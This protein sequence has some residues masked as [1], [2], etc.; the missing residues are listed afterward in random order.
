[1]RIQAVICTF[2]P[3]PSQPNLYRLMQLRHQFIPNA[4]RYDH[5]FSK[6][7]KYNRVELVSD[8]PEGNDA[9]VI[10]SLQVRLDLNSLRLLYAKSPLQICVP[11]VT[12]SWEHSGRLKFIDRGTNHHYECDR[13]ELRHYCHSSI[14]PRTSSQCTVR[15]E[16]IDS[17]KTNPNR[18]GTL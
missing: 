5:A 10:S 15:R 18:N 17:C 16:G 3:S 7:Q 13:V 12:N 9:E 2:F 6:K 8:F 1:M 11:H 14:A 4:A